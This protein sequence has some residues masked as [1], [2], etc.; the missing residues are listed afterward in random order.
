VSYLRTSQC[1]STARPDRSGLYYER[2]PKYKYRLT[3]DFSASVPELLGL[4]AEALARYDDQYLSLVF[5]SMP[6]LTVRAGYAWNGASGPT[7][8]T[9]A[10]MDASL[11]H[12]S[13]YQITRLGVL[14]S[15]ARKP[16]DRAFR[17]ILLE[18]GMHPWRAAIWYYG[19]RLCGFRAARGM[20]RH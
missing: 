17:R 11:V 1:T 6:L 14:P 5:Q 8:D 20:A 3:R 7:L 13:L 10:T 19:V 18:D 9:D 2:I 16:A 4:A 15:S 12:D